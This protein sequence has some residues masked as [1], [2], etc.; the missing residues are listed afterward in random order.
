LPAAAIG[1]L[2]T[3]DVLPLELAIRHEPDAS[4]LPRMEP[5]RSKGTLATLLF[6]IFH[7]RAE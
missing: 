2:R 3:A 4:A 7:G 1:S 5:L 6:L